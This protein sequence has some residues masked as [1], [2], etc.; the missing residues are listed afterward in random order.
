MKVLNNTWYYV[1][2]ISFRHSAF[3]FEMY[4]VS[5]HD[6]MKIITSGHGLVNIKDII[7][8]FFSTETY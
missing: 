1:G 5:E 6:N 7:A 3:I 8:G 4:V 2:F